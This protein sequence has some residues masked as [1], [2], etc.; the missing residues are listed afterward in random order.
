M[1]EVFLRRMR[2]S[3]G[4]IQ[5]HGLLQVRRSAAPDR[6]SAQITAGGREGS[7]LFVLLGK[8]V[9]LVGPDDI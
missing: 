2:A 6:R 1:P 5:T 3:A 8:S 9:R 4:N 7:V